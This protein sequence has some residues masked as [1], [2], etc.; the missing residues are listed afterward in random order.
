MVWLVSASVVDATTLTGVGM[1]PACTRTLTNPWELVILLSVTLP[2]ANCKPPTLVSKLK[3]T[4]CC[5]AGWP[6]ALVTKKVTNDDSVEPVP[7]EPLMRIWLGSA[8]TKL[9]LDNV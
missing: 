3:L 5:A 9:T 1:V 6:F 8:D 2:L 7:P 4:V